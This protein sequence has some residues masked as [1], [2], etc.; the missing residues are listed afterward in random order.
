VGHPPPPADVRH[1]QRPIAELTHAA[2]RSTADPSFSGVV[3]LKIN[4]AAPV[5]RTPRSAHPKMLG[6]AVVVEVEVVVVAVTVG[7]MNS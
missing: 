1:D 4:A 6:Q 5:R 2:G 7:T 3:A